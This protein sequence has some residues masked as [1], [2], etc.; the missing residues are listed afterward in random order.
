MQRSMHIIH[1]EI[2][3]VNIIGIFRVNDERATSSHGDHPL[4]VPSKQLQKVHNKF[5]Q[6]LTYCAGSLSLS[7][8]DKVQNFNDGLASYRTS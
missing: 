7:D 3:G 5:T 8:N 2:A 4:P 1:V 6:P